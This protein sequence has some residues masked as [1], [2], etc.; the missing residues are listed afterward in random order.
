MSHATP[1][2]GRGKRLV[3]VESPFAGDVK[4]NLRYLRAALRDCLLRGEAPFA[5]H[6][7]YTQPG[8][9]DDDNADDRKLGMEAGFAYRDAVDVSVVYTDLGIT[10]GMSAGIEDSKVKGRTTE[11]RMLGPDW[12]SQPIYKTRWE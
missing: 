10:P 2:S 8:V 7:M 6:A 4:Q 12:D 1:G 3:I 5:S 11:Y 9:L